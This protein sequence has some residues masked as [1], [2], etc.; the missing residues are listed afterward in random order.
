MLSNYFNY[1]KIRILLIVTFISSGSVKAGNLISIPSLDAFDSVSWVLPIRKV[2][3]DGS[4]I[5]LLSQKNIAT[6]LF[7]PRLVPIFDFMD[8][9]NSQFYTLEQ[10]ALNPGLVPRP[11]FRGPTQ[12]YYLDKPGTPDQKKVLSLENRLRELEAK[13]FEI[14]ARP[15]ERPDDDELQAFILEGN[16]RLSAEKRIEYLSS[17]ISEAKKK[18]DRRHTPKDESSTSLRPT[19]LEVKLPSPDFLTLPAPPTLE[20]SERRNPIQSYRKKFARSVL[21]FKASVPTAQGKERPA[22]ASDFYLT[23]R[24]LQDLLSDLNLDSALA[25]EVKSVAELW[26]QAEKDSTANPEIALGVKSILL[27][28]KVGK[29]R[30]DPF[31]N[32]ELG[33][34]SPDDKYFLIGID[35]DDQTGVVTIW[36]KHVEVG[37]G[38]N[39][40]ELTT[41]DVI[42]QE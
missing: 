38:E 15:D 4:M 17:V 41:K 21:K 29:A 39:M 1:N 5:V 14:E 20:E 9:S 13:L 42:Y 35:K 27:Q 28:A 25:G 8:K 34:V 18:T 22:Q 23:T 31:G 36:S 7:Y 33:D 24:N 40:V 30:T 2:D 11:A 6:P 12:K 26:A 10:L 19:F 3:D 37:L 32:G 16:D